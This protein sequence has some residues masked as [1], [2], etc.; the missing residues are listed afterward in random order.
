[1]TRAMQ[2]HVHYST[3]LTFF[4]PVGWLAQM[5]CDFCGDTRL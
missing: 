2:Y 5:L 1:M 4:L 3:V